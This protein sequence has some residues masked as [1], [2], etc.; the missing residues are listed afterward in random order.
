MRN[1]FGNTNHRN[2]SAYARDEKWLIKHH[3]GQ[4]V[5]YGCGRRLAIGSDPDEVLEKATKRKSDTSIM[6]VQVLRKEDRIN[7]KLRTLDY[8]RQKIKP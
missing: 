6:M 5:A 8:G 4:W 1:T 3:F 2:S 7:Y